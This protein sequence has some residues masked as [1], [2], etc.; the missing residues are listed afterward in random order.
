MFEDPLLPTAT[1]TT[2]ETK[3]PAPATD[4]STSDA[5][6]PEPS[7]IQTAPAQA[8][9]PPRR[10]ATAA[11]LI[12]WIMSCLLAEAIL[13]NDAAE[14]AAFWLISTWF[15]TELTIRPCLIITGPAHEASRVLHMLKR[16]CHWAELLAEFRRSDLHQLHP[17][18]TLLVSEPNLNKRTANLISGMTDKEFSVAVRDGGRYSRSIA[19]YAG[20]NPET[21]QIRNAIHIHIA[22]TNEALPD[23]PPRLEKMIKRLPVHL[24]QYCSKNL[25]SVLHS[26]WV[27][28]GLSA[29]TAAIATALGKC[30]VDAPE[31]R[32]RLVALLKI[33]DQQSLSE[34]SSTTD[35]VVVEATLALSLDGQVYASCGEI[36]A[37]A[38]ELLKARGETARLSP[39][40][41]GHVLNRLG[42]PTRWLPQK[43]KG[44]IFDKATSARIRELA[45]MYMVDVMEDPPAEIENLHS[46]QAA[47][48]KCVEE[49]MEVMEVF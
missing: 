22:P 38:N 44:L 9:L 39:E 32:Q 10:V 25:M 16:F 24:D 31:L 43:R 40:N 6:I 28:S 7:E 48:N 47:E 42:L 19:I 12:S 34:M 29:E 4:G 8:P 13:P 30:I 17:S 46:Q 23:P 11:E 37:K 18:S 15:Q 1:D 3:Y 36:A 20:E 27:P 2:T 41:V 45:A 33:Q 26:T 49:V 14:L 21:H 35:A 5:E